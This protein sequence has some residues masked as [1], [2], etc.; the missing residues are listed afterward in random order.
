MSR[1]KTFIENLNT[2]Q[3]TQLE[4]GKKSGKSDAFRTRC[5]A[6]LL[7]NKGFSVSEISTILSVSESAIFKWFSAWKKHGFEGLKTKS[8]QGRKPVLCADNKDH[9]KGV[10]KAVKKVAEKGGNLL[11]EIEAELGFKEQ[12][13]MRMV[14]F[15]LQ[16]LTSSTNDA[17]RK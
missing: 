9:V 1:R 14:H 5:H 6:I 10:E 4:S 8:G 16:K 3:I 17:E 15:F 11:A 2:E 7:S 13:S 12:L